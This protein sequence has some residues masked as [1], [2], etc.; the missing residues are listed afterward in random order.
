MRSRVA[1]ACEEVDRRG[2]EGG[3]RYATGPSVEGGML[4]GSRKLWAR[5][6]R[7]RMWLVRLWMVSWTSDGGAMVS[8][9]VWLDGGWARED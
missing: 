7:L 5:L 9:D 2:R 6:V 1:L 8:G 4:I 3:G